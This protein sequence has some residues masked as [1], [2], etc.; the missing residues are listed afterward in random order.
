MLKREWAVGFLFIFASATAFADGAP[1]EVK[2]DR[3]ELS[4]AMDH[5]T[6]I[7]ATLHNQGAAP[8]YVTGI[9]VLLSEGASGDVYNPAFLEDKLRK[10]EPG[11]TWDSPLA[12]VRAKHR[13]PLAVKGSLLV[14]GGTSP[15]AKDVLA[16]VP[17]YLSVADARR[18]VDGSFLRDAVPACDRPVNVCCDSEEPSC[19]QTPNTCVYVA[20]GYD[21]QEVCVDQQGG[22]IYEHISDVHVS[23]DG[24]HVAYI[25]S[26]SCFSGGAEEHCKRTVVVDRAGMTGPGVGVPSDLMLS[27]D[28]KHYAYT[29]RGDC[30]RKLGEEVCSGAS[31]PVLLTGKKS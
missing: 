25:A 17:I 24:A 21:R 19:V 8:L 27:P 30:I 3:Y 28:G 12:I 9:R 29:A 11:E 7:E 20:E 6:V 5:P 31:V 23:S 2:L 13:G 14:S 10:L 15:N 1:L 26:A 4:V 22:K 16:T 18:Q